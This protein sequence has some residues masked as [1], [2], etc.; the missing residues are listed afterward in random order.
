MIVYQELATLSL[1]LGIS[2]RT[3]Y[4]VSNSI[5]SHYHKVKIPKKNGGYRSLTIPDSELKLIQRRINE[6]LLRYSTVSQYATAYRF[7]G[8]I[9]RNA[10]PHVGANTILK[11]DIYKFFDSIIY[12]LVK[13]KVFAEDVYSEQN[14]TLLTSLCMYKD[15]LP[16]GAPTS[17]VISNIIM[18]EFD[19]AVGA[20]C[21]NKGIVYT[22]YCDDMTF[23]GCFE[24]KEVIQFIKEKLREI[25]LFLN[26]R[27]TVIASNGQKKQ[28]T[29]IVVNEKLS[30]DVNYIRLIRQEVYYIK[31]Y[32]ITSHLQERQIE[33]VPQLYLQKLLGRINFVLSVNPSDIKM[34][35]YKQ[36]IKKLIAGE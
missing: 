15:C 30:V 23:S 17:P 6:R 9:V 1:D 20:W 33:M 32:G 29:G 31:K 16:Q 22:R 7:G 34:Q 19:N 24:P 3:L 2:V 11:L 10:L 21:D 26:A 25:G 4:S 13:D 27:K 35:E 5:S 36:F 12:S 28:V 18:Y 14:R 8:G